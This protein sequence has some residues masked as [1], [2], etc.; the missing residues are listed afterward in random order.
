MFV[1][2]KK[3]SINNFHTHLEIHPSTAFS[4]VTQIVPFANHNQAPRVYFHAAQSKQAICIPQTNFNKRMDTMTYVHHYPQKRIITTRGCN[5][6]GIE[7]MPHGFNVIVAIMAHGFNQE[8]SIIINKGSIDRGLFHITKYKTMTASEKAI[9]IRENIVIENPIKIRDNGKEIKNIDHA[10]YSLLD[11]NGFIKEGSYIPKGQKVAVLGMV[12][13]KEEIVEKKSGVLVDYKTKKTYSD[14]SLISDIAHH[15]YIDKVYVSR[16]TPIN[17]E[18]IAKIKFRKTKKPELGD[19]HCS[20]HGQKG[21]IGMILDEVNMPFTK[22][23]IR[24]DIIINPH[25]IP[26]RMTIGHLVETV[27]AKLCCLEGCIGDG[28]VFIDFDKSK[29]YEELEKHNFEKHGN[30]I[31]YNGRSGEQISTEIFMGPIFYYRLKHMVDDKIHGR[32]KGPKAQLTR[33][34]TSGRSNDGGLRIGEME[35]DVL[36]SHGFSQFTKEC[37]MEKS[38]KYR[39][40]VCKYCGISANFTPEKNNILCVSCGR[41]DLSIIETPYAFKLLMQEIQA[42]GLQMRLS[43]D[44]FKEAE[45][46]E[47]ADEE[48]EAHEEVE[49]LEES[50]E[51][52]GGD[53]EDEEDSEEEEDDDDDEEKE[54]ANEEINQ[55]TEIN[56]PEREIDDKSNHTDSDSSI[57][58]FDINENIN[59]GFGQGDQLKEKIDYSVNTDLVNNNQL[60]FSTYG[61]EKDNISM[62]GGY[63]ELLGETDNEKVK[64]IGNS[65]NEVQIQRDERIKQSTGG[66]STNITTK[67][68]NIDSKLFTDAAN[69]SNAISA[70]ETDDHDNSDDDNQFFQ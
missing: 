57:P 19:K 41:Q 7:R 4:V 44:G 40:S 62:I 39:W 48:E 58:R 70:G 61:G 50:S 47:E 68:I 15:G 3:E 29:I 46:H 53:G 42:M 69:A 64:F 54:E 35:R 59:N 25:A 11:D 63:S 22:D 13:V 20:A 66:N 21:V 16:Q 67:V 5:Y 23:G 17:K 27:F 51:I 6:N 55:L 10:K 24:P 14:I 9:N 56:D 33:Q 38:D 12:H 49:E 60:N 31:L 1:A 18:R 45:E 26:S 37:M 8:D 32:G 36:I 43:T 28:T 52:S 34:P 65:D 2:M 30:E